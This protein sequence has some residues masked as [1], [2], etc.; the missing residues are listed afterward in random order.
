MILKNNFN[1]KKIVIDAS[2]TK[3]TGGIVHL[4]VYSKLQK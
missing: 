3:S 4:N 2:V 1:E